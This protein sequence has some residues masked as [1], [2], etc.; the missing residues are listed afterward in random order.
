MM[1]IEKERNRK[2]K[3]RDI[4]DEKI[5]RHREEEKQIDVHIDRQS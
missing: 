5:D 2:V 1:E 4:G 3:Q